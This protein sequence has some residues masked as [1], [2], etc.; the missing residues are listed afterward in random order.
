MIF[1]FDCEHALDCDRNGISIL[2]GDCQNRII[3]GYLL[4]VKEILDKM[5]QLSARAQN[6]ENVITSTSRFFPSNHRLFLKAN[7]N[8]VY[9]YVKVGPKKLFVRDRL[10]N[11][12]ERKC[13]CVLDFYVYDSVQRQ[14]IGKELFDFMLNYEK[15]APDVLAYDRPTL[16]LLAFLKKNYGLENYITQNNSF[17]IFDNFFSPNS[18]LNLDTEFDNDTHRVIQSL[19]TPKNIYDNYYQERKHLSN[20]NNLRNNYSPRQ[21]PQINPNNYNNYKHIEYNSDNNYNRTE[22]NNNRLRSMSPIGEQLIY[23]NDY[24]NSSINRY[25]YK[26][27]NLNSDNDYQYNN[28]YQKNNFDNKQINYEKSYDDKYEYTQPNN[29]YRSQDFINRKEY[30]DYQM[31]GKKSPRNG[32]SYFS[33]TEYTD[34]YNLNNYYN[35][36]KQ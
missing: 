7:K 14:G 36:N 29:N 13:L 10:F 11:Y 6:L 9:G 15:I 1:N 2:E 18:I 35:N 30:Q 5:G 25:N 21:S 27:P 8:R 34:N 23:S 3:P 26:R 4:Y 28:R 16:R 33:T 17:I 20:R 19:Q 32:N 22:N 31:N 12:H 24:K